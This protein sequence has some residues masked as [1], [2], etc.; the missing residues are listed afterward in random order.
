M[1]RE[2]EKG[3]GGLVAIRIKLL[4]NK[5]KR[6]I[7]ERRLQR[8]VTGGPRAPRKHWSH[9]MEERCVEKVGDREGVTSDD[10]FTQTQGLVYAALRVWELK[11][12]F[13]D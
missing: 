4:M 5:G 9:A 13:S 8:R 1:M 6:G 11:H 12:G 7:F 2:Q 10:G 3:T